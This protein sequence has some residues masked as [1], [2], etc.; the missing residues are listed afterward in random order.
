VPQQQADRQGVGALV[1]ARDRQQVLDD[2]VQALVS[3]SMA[4]TTSRRTGAEMAGRAARG[5]RGG[6]S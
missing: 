4:A 5:F 1:M 2:A 6:W 3:S